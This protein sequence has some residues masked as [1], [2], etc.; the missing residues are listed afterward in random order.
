[1]AGSCAVSSQTKPSSFRSWGTGQSEAHRGD[2]NGVGPSGTRHSD[3]END[4]NDNDGDLGDEND[5]TREDDED[6]FVDSDD[7]DGN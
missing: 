2:E 6:K 1:M 4:D 5:L 3:D 7:N